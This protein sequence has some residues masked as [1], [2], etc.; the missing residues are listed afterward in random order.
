MFNEYSKLD[1]E[2]YLLGDMKNEFINY[3][4]EVFKTNNNFIE[5]LSWGNFRRFKLTIDNQK[6]WLNIYF[7]L[8]ND[9][10]NIDIII[11][12]FKIFEKRNFMII[13]YNFN[14]S[15]S[16]KNVDVLY[17]NFILE[18]NNLYDGI[19]D[20][21]NINKNIKKIAGDKPLNLNNLKEELQFLVNEN[22]N[23]LIYKII[24][25]PNLIKKKKKNI[26][27]NFNKNNNENENIL[28]DINQKIFCYTNENT[29]IYGNFYNLINFLLMEYFKFN[30]IKVNDPNF[31]LNN[32]VPKKNEKFFEKYTNKII[33]SINVIIVI[34]FIYQI[35]IILSN[36][37]NN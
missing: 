23:N 27:K 9:E 34:F 22:E 19:L 36:K 15:K 29:E 33:L 25:S 28:Y 11:N 24:F 20:D 4:S 14:D 37:N 17:N 13:L 32:F 30:K 12:N 3:L 5:T 18:R 26:K 6:L 31:K 16:I 21:E 1:M 2:I 7:I 10:Q 35:I 8:L